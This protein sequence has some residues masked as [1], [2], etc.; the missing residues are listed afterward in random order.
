MHSAIN[1]IKGTF[2][3]VIPTSFPLQR[4]YSMVS[5]LEKGL[6]RIKG[7][8]WPSY[9]VFEHLITEACLNP[10]INRIPS[11][12]SLPQPTKGLTRTAPTHTAI[13]LTHITHTY[14]E[15]HRSLLKEQSFCCCLLCWLISNLANFL[16]VPCWQARNQD[17]WSTF[18]APSLSADEDPCV[19]WKFKREIKLG[20]LISSGFVY[21]CL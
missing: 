7:C 21:S 5:C 10:N 13:I 2:V 1:Q 15:R 19:A 6:G 18:C 20:W 8:F 16:L 4:D 12:R 9:L 17:L 11:T 3:A 14:R